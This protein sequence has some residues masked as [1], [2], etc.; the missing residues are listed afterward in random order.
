MNE[1]E[2]HQRNGLYKI[3]VTKL[4][5]SSRI[6]GMQTGN[7]YRIKE[8][9]S[10]RS[11]AAGLVE[12]YLHNLLTVKS[13]TGEWY[14]F[15]DEELQKTVEKAK[16]YNQKVEKP[17]ARVWHYDQTLSN[18]CSIPASKLALNIHR[19]MISQMN[20]QLILKADLDIY[21]I[22]LDTLTSCS[23][24]ITGL[25]KVTYSDP[26]NTFKIG[27]FKRRFPDI[28]HQCLTNDYLHCDF[29]IIG[30]PRIQD[31]PD[32]LL[33]LNQA[34]WELKKK[35]SEKS[36]K[37]LIITPCE[38]SI[39]YWKKYNSTL[40]KINLLKNSIKNNELKLRYLCGENEIIENVCSY[41]RS[42]ER[43]LDKKQLR[44]QFPKEYRD[45]FTR[46]GII[47]RIRILNEK[48][49][50]LHLKGLNNLS[51]TVIR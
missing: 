20:R 42:V 37:E 3:G 40:K 23:Q 41:K 16:Q 34:K 32:K 5:L 49:N 50:E 43:R 15:S 27:H 45:C 6:R 31:H 8:Y 21:K 33:E 14:R 24:G 9:T 51:P 44:S 25:T 19:R 48:E 4:P 2:G 7:P 12:S 13:F 22:R 1:W 46:R 30:Q 39:K 36:L 11:K 18:G 26:G 35:S 47:R 38:E 10:L 29:K 28:H 17:A